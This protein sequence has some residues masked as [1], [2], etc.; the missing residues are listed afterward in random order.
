MSDRVICPKCGHSNSKYRVTC[1]RCRVNLAQAVSEI[2]TTEQPSSANMEDQTI[3]RSETRERADVGWTFWF[4]LVVI[5][6]LGGLVVGAVGGFV[7]G[8]VPG[9]VP[10]PGFMVI[11]G[12][13][14]G[15]VGG[16]MAGTIQLLTLRRHISQP[17]AWVLASIIVAAVV[18]AGAVDWSWAVV[19]QTGTTGDTEA[20]AILG[21]MVGAVGGAVA[22]IQQRHILR[23][24]VSQA[25]NW[26][27][28]A[29]TVGWAVGGAVFLPAFWACA[30]AIV[31][32]GNPGALAAR[33]IDKNSAICKPVCL[34]L[35]VIV[36]IWVIAQ[37]V[38]M[39]KRQ[40]VDDLQIINSSEADDQEE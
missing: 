1:K 9:F 22:G 21:V 23:Q 31:G 29:N 19:N 12:A 6:I 39:W 24:H 32:G 3:E 18:W 7:G 8:F 10:V 37:T 35:I 15:A 34:S 13:V 17:A 20:W 36:P 26:W 5:S 38:L 27:V 4:N 25:A 16:I 33:E 14:G 2:A 28:L 30:V 40:K 11:G